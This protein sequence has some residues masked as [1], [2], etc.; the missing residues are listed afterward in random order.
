MKVYVSC[1]FSL[2]YNPLLLCPNLPLTFV[3][4]HIPVLTVVWVVKEETWGRERG[5]SHGEARF[6]V[7]RWGLTQ[8]SIVVWNDVRHLVGWQVSQGWVMEQVNALLGILRTPGEG[9]LM[10]NADPLGE[11]LSFHC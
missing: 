2:Y 5:M 3:K 11:L 8:G 4:C 10:R 9:S 1:R 6:N 7:A